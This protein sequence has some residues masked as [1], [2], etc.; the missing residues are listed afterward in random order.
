VRK[1]AGM[2]RREMGK[3]KLIYCQMLKKTSKGPRLGP[4]YRSLVNNN[5]AGERNGGK[6]GLPH[7]DDSR[8]CCQTFKG[9]EKGKRDKR[10]KLL[11]KKSRWERRKMNHGGNWLKQLETEPLNN[12][13]T[14]SQSR[15]RDEGWGRKTVHRKSWVKAEIR[16]KE[17][18]H[19]EGGTEEERERGSRD[20]YSIREKGTGMEY[21]LEQETSRP[22]INKKPEKQTEKDR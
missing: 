16:K 8:Q 15:G 11:Q 9:A 20:I 17:I 4:K 7:E 1:P 21:K 10:L 18:L 5:F 13:L 2:K 6:R 19:N 22:E 12:R 14:V 3:I